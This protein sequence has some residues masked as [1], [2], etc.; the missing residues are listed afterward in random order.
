MSQKKSMMSLFKPIIPKTLSQPPPPQGRSSNYHTQGQGQSEP[1]QQQQNQPRGFGGATVSHGED[2][3][4]LPCFSFGFSQLSPP[5]F[6]FL[7][8]G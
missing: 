2:G 4:F 8:F 7:F 1:Q 6:P 3:V 5:C